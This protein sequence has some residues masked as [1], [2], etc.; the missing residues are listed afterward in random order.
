MDKAKQDILWFHE[1]DKDDTPLVGG[2][3]ANL[4]EMT[5]A[6]LPVPEGFIV[7][8]KAFFDFLAKTGLNK[9]I[10]KLTKGID[11]ND[12]KRLNSAS[13]EI[14]TLILKA[15]MPGGL[16]KEIEKGYKDLYGSDAKGAFVAVRSSG[17]TEDLAEASFAGQNESF[18][19]VNG[20]ENVVRAVQK[21][22][23]S[24]FYA[25]S[26]YYRIANKFDNVKAGIAVPIM[27]MVQSESSGVMF[28]I[29]PVQ[30]DD[31]KVVI[32]AGL[33][34]GEAVVLGA[35]TPDRYII[36]KKSFEITDKEINA[37]EWQIVKVGGVDKHIALTDEEKKAQKLPDER[38]IELAKIA[39]KIESHYG[40][41]QDMEWAL[42]N[43]KIYMIQ[44]RPVTT[45]KK[46]PEGRSPSGGPT[47]GDSQTDATAPAGI[48]ASKAKV[49]VKG[50]AASLGMASGPVKIIHKP[51]ENDQVL[52]GDILVTEKTNP[53]FVPA[54]QRAAAIVTDT[55]GRTSHAAIVSREMG[56][57]CVVGTGT[58]SHVLKT[59]QMVTVDGVNGVVYQG[60]VESNV[61]HE[62]AANS[63]SSN[64][65]G[66]AAY[67]EEIP[68]TATKVYLNLAEPE[69]A[70]KAAALPVDGVGLLRAEF[71]I[72]AG[73]KHP[74]WLVENG[75]SEEYV[76]ILYEG[77]NKIASAF[78]PRPVIYRATDFKTNEYRGLEGGEKYEPKEENPMIGY[79]GAFRYIKEPDLFKLELEAIKK[80]RD[81]GN[82]N[83]WLMIPFIR[84][85]AEFET[86]SKMVEDF[87]LTRGP[88]FKLYIMCEVPSTVLLMEEFCKLGIDGV[89]IGSNDLTQL[90]LGCDRDNENLAVEFDERN[91]A[92][93]ASIAHVI[94]ICR[95]YHV[96]VSICGQAPSVYPEITELMVRC[97]TTSVSVTQ[98][99]VV[100][101]RKLI[102]SVEKKILLSE[103]I[104]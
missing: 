78:N 81:Q 88:D 27:R 89:S 3:G 41:P 62:T 14:R 96:S 82:K 30:N 61:A 63:S 57:P 44:S 90:T 77:I 76:N 42:E 100:Q 74:R 53:D 59:G 4:G 23:A 34:L 104:D 36:D 97:G 68:V 11:A 28:S 83:L 69:M 84:T 55:G 95:K 58:G 85:I 79:R 21:C 64:L 50:A 101:T 56:I 98:D 51:S 18:L 22:W 17:I 102:A 94:K 93:T 35:I 8:S 10:S 7:T 29:D 37:Q 72:A 33:G 65:S 60:K 92:V 71:I 15:K 13:K 20:T 31:T 1:V 2:K 9:K 43:E 19:N 70:E 54:M 87:G 5:K 25:R 24:L 80:V 32:E 38:V 40:K 75:K 39:V 6:G 86:I 12:S 16:V 48:D 49:L 26:I 103:A 52:K 45:F 47:A 99:V 91:P 73:G 66:S 46:S 67:H